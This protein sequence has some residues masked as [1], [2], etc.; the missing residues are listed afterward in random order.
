MQTWTAAQLRMFL[1]H[2]RHDRL[3]ALWHL[4]SMTGMRR[5]E[6]LGLRWPDVDL[7]TGRVAV[8]RALVQL[9]GELV[10][11]E[12]KTAQGRRSVAIDPG[13]VT[14]LKNHQAG[15]AVDQVLFGDA[16]DQSGLLFTRGRAADPAR[17]GQ[18]LVRPAR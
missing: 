17:A 7:D 3:Y 10:W 8:R 1:N 16:Y 12:P 15:Q 14:A 18:R 5:G 11:S 4:A 13:T 9:R 2:V 6:L